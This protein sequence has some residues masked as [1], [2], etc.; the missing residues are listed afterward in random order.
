MKINR[1]L[2]A[3]CCAFFLVTAPALAEKE[4][5]NIAKSAI[6]MASDIRQLKIKKNVPCD[7]HK[8]EQVKEY[9]LHVLKTKIPK[10]KMSNE[11]IVYKAIGM[12]PESFSYE[13]GLVD[14]YLSQIGGYYDPDKDHFIM[15]GWMPDILQTTVAVHELTHALQDQ[16]FNLD[17]FIFEKLEN[18][19]ETLSRSA[20]VEGDATAVMLDYARVISGQPGIVEE[21]N[22]Q[23]FMMQTVLSVSLVAGNANVPKSLQSLLIFPYTSGLRFVHQIL[24]KGGYKKVD[25]AFKRPPRSTEEILH[26]EKYFLNKKDFIDIKDHELRSEHLEEG[27]EVDY[28]DTFGEFGISAM[29]ST[30]NSATETAASASEGWGGDRIGILKKGSEK[31]VLWKL[32]WD[33]EE[34]AREFYNTYSKC[35]SKR[36]D[37]IKFDSGFQK[38]PDN[39]KL[40]LSR[41]G[42]DV[43]FIMRGIT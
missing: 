5:C 18:S 35:L 16:Y 3:L 42:S 14:F 38:I 27:F 4:T 15:A 20:L 1:P 29:L 17:K 11:E 12:I 32:H 25:E 40:L 36:F 21:D 43:L 8:K 30:C 41:N 31:S 10:D 19:D 22:V 34:D 24:K 7:V 37:G 2:I 23:S 13:D 39:R 26:P 28:S 9:I 6:K 33:T